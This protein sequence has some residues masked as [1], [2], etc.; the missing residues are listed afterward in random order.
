MT[1]SPVINHCPACLGSSL[2]DFHAVESV[3]TNSCLLLDDMADVEALPTGRL[4]LAMCETCGFI[5]NRAFDPTLTEYSERYEE[6]QAFSECFVGWAEELAARWVADHDLAGKTAIE[7]GCGKGEFLEFMVRA[8]LEGGT[9]I[10]PGVRPERRDTDRIRW[11]R[12]FFDDTYGQIT[13]DA[14]VCRHTLEHIHDVRAFM[15]DVRTAIGDRDIPVLWEVPDVLRVLEEGAFWDLYYEHCAYF[16]AGSLV[17][18]FRETGFE[19]TDVSLAYDDQYILLE[20]R[21]SGSDVAAPAALP[22]ED[23]VDVLRKAVRGFTEAFETRMEETRAL[24]DEVAA[25][26]GR[27]VIWGSGSKGVSYLG[28]L[29]EDTPIRY[30]VDINPHKHGKFIAGGGQEIV[31]P[32]FL[33]EY[34]PALVIAMNPVYTAE[35]QA[36]LDAMG[37]SARL[38]AV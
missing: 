13:E 36:E 27:T 15:Q 12:A 11:Q 32:D 25:T 14:V 19:V 3:P 31:A 2:T 35:I 23:D 5:T 30:A 34:D 33:R 8:G 21:P 16:T 18:L 28:A 9:G 10:D 17:R 1:G 26:G 24:V 4:Q 6:T 29:G 7:I 37:S 22:L 20:A 38:V